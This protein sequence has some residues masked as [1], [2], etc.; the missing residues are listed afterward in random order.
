MGFQR[1]TWSLF[2]PR[3]ARCPSPIPP[4][5][6]TFAIHLGFTVPSPRWPCP[7]Q[8]ARRKLRW[9]IQGYITKGLTY[10]NKCARRHPDVSDDFLS[11]SELVAELSR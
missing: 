7:G 1:W 8:R 9:L 3:S 10:R 11:L 2:S 6:G 5:F 4:L